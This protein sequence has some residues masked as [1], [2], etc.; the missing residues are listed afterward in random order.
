MCEDE[1]GSERGDGFFVETSFS[2]ESRNDSETFEQVI[3]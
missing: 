1:F 3:L 2:S